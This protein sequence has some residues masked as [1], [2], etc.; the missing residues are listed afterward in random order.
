MNHLFLSRIYKENI[1][2]NKTHIDICMYQVIYFSRGGNTKKL[3]EAI[4]EGLNIS[5][6]DVK[7]ARLRS[8]SDMVFLGSGCYGGKPGK[9]M[10]EFINENDLEGQD[11]ALFGTSGGG[12][13]DELK[14]MRDALKTKGADIKGKFYCKGQ[15]FWLINH[16]RPDREDLKRAEEFAEDMIEE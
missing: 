2:R 1:L 7:K 9:E 12:K 15:T 14:D 5:A 13:G 16:G 11:V 6:E 4:A 8:E 3:A 10:M